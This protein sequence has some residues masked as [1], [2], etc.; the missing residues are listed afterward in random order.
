MHSCGCHYFYF[1]APATDAFSIKCP[2]DART[3]V[4]VSFHTEFSAARAPQ[5]R[6]QVCVYDFL[7]PSS[8]RGREAIKNA[9]VGSHRGALSAQLSSARSPE[10]A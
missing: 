6:T 4:F 1:D 5:T 2:T 8:P 10:D 9:L 3:G 7:Y